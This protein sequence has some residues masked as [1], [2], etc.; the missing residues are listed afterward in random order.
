MKLLFSLILVA[1]L[2]Y[3]AWPYYEVYRIDDALGKND[4]TALSEL[5]D[6]EAIRG[7]YKHRLTKSMT[8]MTGPADTDSPMGWLQH[9]LT[10]LGDSALEQAITV[11]WLRDTLKQAAIRASTQQTPYF[12]GSISFAFFESLDSFLIRLGR[13]DESPTYVRLQLRDKAWRITDIVE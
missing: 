5:A 12:I 8:R 4:L 11:E 1:L 9:N 6:L 10:R 2:A 13:I 7:N 3:V